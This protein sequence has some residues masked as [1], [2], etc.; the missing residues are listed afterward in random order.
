[1]AS[2]TNYI[3]SCARLGVLRWSIYSVV[4]SATPATVVICVF[5]ITTCIKMIARS[6]RFATNVAQITRAGNRGANSD[7]VGNG[8]GFNGIGLS[9]ILR[10]GRSA[11]GGEGA[12]P[13]S[14]KG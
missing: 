6:C 14:T 9:R 2:V 7:G 8:G 5:V 3:I 1:M 11:R 10:D 4:T 13:S 12:G